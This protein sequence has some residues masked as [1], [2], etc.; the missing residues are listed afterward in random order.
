MTQGDSSQSPSRRPT[1]TKVSRAFLSIWRAHPPHPRERRLAAN[2]RGP[3][4]ESSLR[5]D[6]RLPS[7]STRR[8]LVLPSPS[9]VIFHLAEVCLNQPSRA[10][11]I[12][13]LVT[14]PAAA[15]PR[16]VSPTPGLCRWCVPALGGTKPWRFRDTRTSTMNSDQPPNGRPAD[17]NPEPM[18]VQADQASTAPGLS[19]PSDNE[20]W[21]LGQSAAAYEG[22]DDVFSPA[23]NPNGSGPPSRRP[24]ALMSR[25]RRRA[26]DN[27]SPFSPTSG[28]FSPGP[29][30]SAGSP[31]TFRED[32]V[33]PYCRNG[34]RRRINSCSSISD[35]MESLL[36]HASPASVRRASASEDH[37]SPMSASG[38]EVPRGRRGSR[39]GRKGPRT[40]VVASCLPDETQAVA[41]VESFMQHSEH[42]LQAPV[43]MQGNAGLPE[44]MAVVSSV[45]LSTPSNTLFP[46]GP[47]PFS[48]AD[49]LPTSSLTTVWA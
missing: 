22:H 46:G 37:M 11:A 43:H 48:P 15:S 10:S 13:N 30:D 21:Q 35:R 49:N 28:L 34:G 1:N 17:A 32:S 23:D 14:E 7:H 26:S 33:S 9:H 3:K 18:V 6:P 41:V 40:R 29:M 45:F 44:S 36:A 27:R 12:R 4:Q 5:L 39:G 8:R 16:L 47:R 24:R 42:L 38:E 25:W 2:H 19:S 31:V 20:M